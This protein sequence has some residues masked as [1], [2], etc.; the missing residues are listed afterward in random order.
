MK[1]CLVCGKKYKKHKY[2]SIEV[3]TDE[4]SLFVR[5]CPTCMKQAEKLAAQRLRAALENQ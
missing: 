5:V 4:L 2:N 3:R 1:K